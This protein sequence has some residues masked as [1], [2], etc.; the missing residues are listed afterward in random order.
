MSSAGFV[1]YRDESAAICARA[2]LE[3]GQIYQFG[4]DGLRNGGFDPV[5][6]AEVHRAILTAKDVLRMAAFEISKVESA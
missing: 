2:A 5:E 4:I 1:D 3:L 6:T